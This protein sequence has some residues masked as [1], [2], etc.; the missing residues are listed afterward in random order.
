MEPQSGTGPDQAWAVLTVAV[1]SVLATTV[2]VGLALARIIPASV[3]PAV[4]IALSSVV[5][6]LNAAAVRWA[7]AKRR[8]GQVERLAACGLGLIGPSLTAFAWSGGHWLACLW[9]AMLLLAG[10]AGSVLWVASTDSGRTE[11]AH[12]SSH[13]TLTGVG[14]AAAAAGTPSVSDGAEVA[15][16]PLRPAAPVS[17]G[18]GLLQRM[19]RRLGDGC[20]TIDIEWQVHFA[21]GESQRSL[22]LPITPPL[23]TLPRV[24][25]E[26][27]DDADVEITVGACHA[28]GVRLDVRRRGTVAVS[29]RSTIGV[30]L[31]ADVPPAAA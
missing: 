25:C 10:L 29:A 30:C 2:S 11:S 13:S 19:E 26:P 16:R 20:E 4:P 31:Q 28:Y 18:D 6:G 23:T 5:L 14:T 12:R 15:V 8:A 17:A 21:A 9:V 24:E 27:L 22:H 3:P 7:Y 1:L